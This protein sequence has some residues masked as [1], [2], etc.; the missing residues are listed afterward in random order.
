MQFCTAYAY[1]HT[2]TS[3]GICLIDVCTCRNPGHYSGL[4]R[5]LGAGGVA[6]L[7]QDFGAKVYME[8]TSSKCISVTAVPP[9]RCLLAALTTSQTWYHTV[10]VTIH[11]VQNT[12]PTSEGLFRRWL[13]RSCV[14]MARPQASLFRPAVSVHLTLPTMLCN[15]LIIG[16]IESCSVFTCFVLFLSCTT[17]PWCRFRR[18]RTEGVR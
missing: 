14:S 16:D 2:A 4:A 6:R 18:Q 15:I 17:M 13:Q 12:T 11:L 9:Q 1:A 10:M 5:L 7:Q 3:V 8:G